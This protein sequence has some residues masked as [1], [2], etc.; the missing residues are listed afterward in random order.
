M[1]KKKY[2]LSLFLMLTVGALDAYC[3]MLHGGMFA[4]M[5]TGNLIKIAIKLATG[6]YSGLYAYFLTII[7]F[8]LGILVA[9]FVMAKVKK[10]SHIL[11]GSAYALY[12]IGILIPLGNLNFLANLIMAFGVGLQLQ[13]IRSI[14]GFAV[15]TTMC[16]GNLRSMTECIGNLIVKKDKHQA[17]GVLIYSTM[18]IA[19][20]LGVFLGGVIIR[21]IIF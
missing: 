12:I 15:A 4:S 17:L 6:D 21:A 7:S 19:F 3:Y 1:E 2:F 13:A 20:T 14:N 11:I 8:T 16:T 10:G 9:F 18:I 5:Q